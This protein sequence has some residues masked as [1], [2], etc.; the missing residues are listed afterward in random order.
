[1]VAGSN[2]MLSGIMSVGVFVHPKKNTDNQKS[3]GQ[4]L[5]VI[6]QIRVGKLHGQG[7]RNYQQD[8][9]GVSDP[10]LLEGS[11]LLAVVADGMG[12]LSDGDKISTTVVETV[13]DGF[14][15][16]QGQGTLEQVLLT[17]AQWSVREVNLFWDQ[18]DIAVAVQPWQWE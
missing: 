7:A 14:S 6:R 15:Y 2:H 13:L 8:S 5:N 10:E 9:F 11:G 12:G 18:T 3:A 17:L 1:M 4:P 16:S